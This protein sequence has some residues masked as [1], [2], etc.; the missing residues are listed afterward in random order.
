[1]YSSKGVEAFS[2]Q[3]GS[4]RLPSIQG[5]TV[6]QNGALHYPQLT[7]KLPLLSAGPIPTSLARHMSQEDRIK[8]GAIDNDGKLASFFKTLSQGAATQIWGAT[9]PELTGKGGSYLEDVHVAE[10]GTE[11][12]RDPAAAEKLWVVTEELVKVHL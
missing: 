2:V 12:A 7:R 8:F 10:V 3:P 9:A 6:H 5:K 1:M 11:Q 4:Y